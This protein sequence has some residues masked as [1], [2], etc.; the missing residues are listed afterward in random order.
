MTYSTE[1]LRAEAARARAAAAESEAAE[2][3]VKIK[4]AMKR[5]VARINGKSNPES[6]DAASVWARTVAK[7]N[8]R[9]GPK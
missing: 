8:S 4:A 9:K 1:Q 3:G 2:L 6:S 7:F 5:T